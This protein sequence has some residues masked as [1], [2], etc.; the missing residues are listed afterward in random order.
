MGFVASCTY[1]EMIG[2]QI[3]NRVHPTAETTH[4]FDD[5]HEPWDVISR[6]RRGVDIHL[7][8]CVQ[9][10]VFS[11]VWIFVVTGGEVF[12]DL[13]LDFYHVFGLVVRVVADL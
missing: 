2:I 12:R 6:V 7:R 3:R 11:P 13:S 1:E 8:L 4:P 5:C 10:P 9:Q